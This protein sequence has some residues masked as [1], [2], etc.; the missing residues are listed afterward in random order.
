MHRPF[1]AIIAGLLAIGAATFAVAQDSPA[2]PTPAAACASPEASPIAVAPAAG[3]AATPDACGPIAIEIDAVDIAFRPKSVTI[4]A[5]TPVTLTIV[6][7]GLALHNFT[8]DELNI[9]VDLVPTAHETIPIN[10][11]AGTY[12]YYCA[13]PGHREAGMFGKLVVQ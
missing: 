12:T 6:N 1:I 7:D 13:V 5:N 4:P 2:T 9:N 10:A 11:P 8:I 3:A